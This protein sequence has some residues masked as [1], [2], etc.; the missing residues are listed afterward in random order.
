MRKKFS[1]L[2][3]KMRPEARAKS[4]AKAQTLSGQPEVIARFPEGE[5]RSES[6]TG[7]G[8]EPGKRHR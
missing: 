1:S 4:R 3:Q 7:Q 8:G 6:F 5:G 2:R